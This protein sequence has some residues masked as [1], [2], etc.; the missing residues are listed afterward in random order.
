MRTKLLL[1]ALLASVAATASAGEAKPPALAGQ[2]YVEEQASLGA[3][4]LTIR[5]PADAE[6]FYG[7]VVIEPNAGAEAAGW[8]AAGTALMAHGDVWVGLAGPADQLADTAKLLRDGEQSPLAKPGLLKRAANLQGVLKI[9]AVGW[10]PAACGV[11]DFIAS[12]KAEQAKRTDGRPLLNGYVLG[13]CD[14][15]QELKPPKGAALI[16]IATEK[17]Y[18]AAA[19]LRRADG[20]VA[21]EDWHRW[22]DI[23]AAGK[24]QTPDAL[25]ASSLGGLDRWM[26]TGVPAPAGKLFDLGDDKRPK[27]DAPGG[28]GA[29]CDDATATFAKDKT[30]PESARKPS[31]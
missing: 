1:A 9:Y 26:R 19:S 13:G 31:L 21:G 16:R 8:R 5:R 11:G 10:G 18:P 7:A 25:L 4:R 30:P 15:V 22:Y 17:D 24:C 20:N 14:K 12:N 29:D 3:T 28:L 27:K 23:Q 2:G 6:K